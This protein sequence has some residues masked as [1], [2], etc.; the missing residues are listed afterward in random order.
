[1]TMKE[2]EREREKMNAIIRKFSSSFPFLNY[3]CH[4]KGCQKQSQFSAPNST[5]SQVNGIKWNK[6]VDLSHTHTRWW[7]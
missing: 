1:M 5:Q 4:L 2:W 6:S 7:L 3:S